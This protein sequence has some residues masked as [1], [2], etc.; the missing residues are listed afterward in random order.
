M[1]IAIVLYDRFTALDA[2]GPYETLGR[3]PDAET[4]F[5]AERTG[6]VRNETGNLALTADRALA[7]V[8]NPDIV[9]VPGG[10]GQE[11]LMAHEP[12][13]DWLRAA[14]A[15]STWTTSVCTGSL[16]LAAA[17]LL[18][19]RRATSHWLTLEELK[20]FGAEPTGERV[21][22]D[23]K[24]VTAA[25]VSSGIDMG[26]TLL[27]RIAGDD[28]ARMVQLATEYD[29]QPPYDAGSPDKA[30]AHVVELLRSHADVML[31]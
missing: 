8:P 22:T 30:P 29:P 31:T 13:L 16:L 27:G 3:L 19:G 23:G 15:G 1:Q 7:D 18:R 21:V 11:S 10:P 20:R 9:V 6:P 14:D 28:H 4:V 12:L 24:Y 26:L 2:V 5:V 25:G 17:G